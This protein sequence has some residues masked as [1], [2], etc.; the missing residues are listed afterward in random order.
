MKKLFLALF[1]V[2]S[3]TFAAPN[4]TQ[5]VETAKAWTAAISSNKGLSLD[6]WIL[7]PDY[8]FN[9]SGRITF[10]SKEETNNFISN[11][12]TL[13]AAL[14]ATIKGADASDWISFSLHGEYGNSDQIIIRQKFSDLGKS[15]KWQIFLNGDLQK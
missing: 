15:D 5:F 6:Q 14:A 4:V 12:K 11:V 13:T 9:I 10:D 7:I 3:S 1:M 2:F 8:G